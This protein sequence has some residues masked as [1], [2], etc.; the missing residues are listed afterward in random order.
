[1]AERRIAM[2]HEH[3]MKVIESLI[4]GTDYVRLQIPAETCRWLL[5]K[6]IGNR[7]RGDKVMNRILHYGWKFMGDTIKFD[8]NGNLLDGQNRLEACATLGVEM[9]SLFVF[10]LDPELRPYL[11][12]G[13]SRNAEDALHMRGVKNAKIVA[14]ATRIVA[15]Y[16]EGKTNQS[17][18]T[19]RIDSYYVKSIDKLHMADCAR[20][21]ARTN[22]R[23]ISQGP[24]TAIAYIFIESG[25]RAQVET[26]IEDLEALTPRSKATQLLTMVRNHKASGSRPNERSLIAW[27][28]QA[29]NGETVDWMP[30]KDYPEI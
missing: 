8:T 10:G 13:K 4:S 23:I 12:A 3:A 15:D 28:I 25:K 7:E 26:F 2:E 9:D 11:D 16:Y 29:M 18:D 14:P 1:V 22:R 27:L 5:E 17:N 19:A 20:K 30:G 6:N 24:L 21:A